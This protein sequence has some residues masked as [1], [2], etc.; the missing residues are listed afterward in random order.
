MSPGEPSGV[1][2][3]EGMPYYMGAF[4][5]VAL[6]WR[7]QA[8]SKAVEAR[9]LQSLRQEVAA[10]K[11]EKENLCHSWACQEEV[12][13][14]SL[15]DARESNAKA[16]KRLTKLLKQVTSLQSKIVALEAAMR[17]SEAQQKLLADQCA[18]WG[19][20][21]EKTE[22][23]L[24]EKMEKLNLLQTEH[25]QFQ[26]E[27]NRLQMEKEALEKQ[28]ASGDSTIE[29]LERAKKELIAEREARDSTIENLERAKGKLID[30]M[31]DIFAEGFKEA[32]AQAA[33]EN[34]RV[35]TSNCNPLNHIVDGK[36]VP[37]DLGD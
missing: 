37:L 31:A 33:C 13:K 26:T 25:D 30:N 2:R 29:E 35:D 23:E 6:E 21:L 1:P 22:G 7:A 16:C 20:S 32:L 12:Y 3:S 24:A 18:A 27:L 19:Q 4:L 11:E 17:T 9:A 5:V 15:R 10:L 14:A 8:K 28:L 36:V 34:P